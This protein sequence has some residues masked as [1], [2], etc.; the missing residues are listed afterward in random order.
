M[1]VSHHRVYHGMCLSRFCETRQTLI[2]AKDQR[3]SRTTQIVF[4]LDINTVSLRLLNIPFTRPLQTSQPLLFHSI[5][6]FNP[7]RSEMEPASAM[8]WVMIILGVFRA[9]I[10][11]ASEMR[12]GEHRNLDRDRQGR[13]DPDYPLS[14]ALSRIELLA[15]ARSPSASSPDA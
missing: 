4:Y 15:F 3:I 5:A 8:F 6:F 9:Y 13:Y 7:K 10:Y 12:R 2:E 14:E 1:F 11:V